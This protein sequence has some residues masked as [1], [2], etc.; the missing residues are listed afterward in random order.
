MSLFRTEKVSKPTTPAPGSSLRPFAEMEAFLEDL[1]AR[2]FE[3]EG[4][5][6]VGAHKGDWTRSAAGVFPNAS[7]LLL[8]PQEELREDLLRVERDVPNTKWIQAGAGAQ[9]GE[10]CF[11]IWDDLAGSTFLPKANPARI[12]AGKQRMTPLVTLDQ[13]SSDRPAFKPDLVKID[14]QGFEM[15]VLR[16]ATTLFGITSIFIVECSLFT[17][18]KKRPIA[19][20]LIAYLGDH[21][22]ELYDVPGFLRRPADGALGQLDLAFALADGPLRRHTSWT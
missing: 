3:P 8:E 6:D 2:G 15:E 7:I 4:I 12:A 21:G 14:V 13:I 20:E 17:A 11:T 19:R 1:H 16:G 22:Y 10:A 18:S 9:A 5:L